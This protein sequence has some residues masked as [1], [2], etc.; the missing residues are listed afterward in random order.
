[1]R[2][3]SLQMGWLAVAGGALLMMSAAAVAQEGRDGRAIDGRAIDSSGDVYRDAE[4]GQPTLPM[5]AAGFGEFVTK[6]AAFVPRGAPGEPMFYHRDYHAQLAE[7]LFDAQSPFHEKAVQTLLNVPREEVADKKV[8]GRIA[9]GYRQVAFAE[10]SAHAAA[11]VRGLVA[12]GGKFSAPLL[13]ELLEK[14]AAAGGGTGVEEALYEGLG[15]LATPECAAAVVE[16]LGAA[17]SSPAAVACL[18]KMG[19]VAEQPL[20]DLLPFESADANLAAINLL[21][22]VGSRKSNAILRKATKSENEDVA[23]AAL[24]AIRKIRERERQTAS[25]K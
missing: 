21:A 11:G 25:A 3:K 23:S 12:W 9:Q 10:G 19:P 6:L 15:S 14:S 13:I 16:R 5:V 18:R 17:T 7:H 2:R 24:E 4:G 1:M 20:V 22:D 8:R